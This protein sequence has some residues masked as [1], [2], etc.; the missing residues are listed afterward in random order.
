MPIFC[1]IA[2]NGAIVNSVN[3]EVSAPNVNKIVHDVE[4]FTLCNLL[5]LELRYCNPFPNGS[6]TK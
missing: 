3:S 4:I 1:V 5:K 2:T 6:A